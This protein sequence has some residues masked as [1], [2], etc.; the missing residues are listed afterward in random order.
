MT[1]PPTTGASVGQARLVSPGTAFTAVPGLSRAVAVL[2]VTE[3]VSWGVLF[4]AFPVLASSISAD[5]DWPMVSLVAA[6]TVALVV[7]GACGIWV[8]TRIDHVGPRAIMTAGSMLAVMAVLALATAPTLSWFFGAWVLAGAAMSATLYAPAFAAVTGW[9][10][11]D[12]RRR[13]RSLTAITLIAGLAST[14]FAPLTAFLLVHL[15]WRDTYLVLAGVLLVTVPLHAWGLRP[16]WTPT[17]SRSRGTPL[18]QHDERGAPAE[19]EHFDVRAFS[20]LVVAMA[21]A[22][23]A[24]YAVVINFMPL[25]TDNGLTTGQAATALGLGGVGQVVGRVFYG[26][27]FARLR[28]TA[29][30]SATVVGVVVT[31]GALA[32]WQS[33][34]VLVCLLSFASGM[35]RGIFT[36]I[37]ATAVVD[38]WGVGDIGH[39]NGILTGAITVVSAFAPWMGAVLAA[40]LGSYDATFAVLA[41]LAAASLLV[42][43]R[44]RRTG[45]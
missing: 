29:R 5:E 26:P 3:I 40:V 11:D 39:R 23:F 16:P 18:E 7:S 14:V 41:G 32:V 34:F 19:I 35:V 28:P 21:M 43:P 20:L 44:A 27:A 8:G 6:F 30:A 17:S 42:L 15:G 25:L 10:G 13:V 37:Q 31:S 24:V 2:S 33:P 1:Q 12:A 22:G 9:S 38:R 45:A 4:Y 36:L